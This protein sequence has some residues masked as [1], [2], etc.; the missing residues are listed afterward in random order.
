MM[1]SRGRRNGSGW[2]DLIECQLLILVLID[3]GW[4]PLQALIAT[5][6]IDVSCKLIADW[7]AP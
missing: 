7:L 5:V 4:S 6:A 3:A 2:E 1:N